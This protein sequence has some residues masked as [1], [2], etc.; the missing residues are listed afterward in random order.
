MFICTNAIGFA[1]HD[2]Y[3]PHN[4]SLSLEPLTAP[5]LLRHDDF[6]RGTLVVCA[7]SVAGEMLASF[8]QNAL[9][10]TMGVYERVQK[11]AL[12]RVSPNTNTSLI[13]IRSE[14]RRALL[15]G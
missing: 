2:D 7:S 4:G 13:R 6:P 12:E 9:L 8:A 14:C 5:I 15:S 10:A 3:F 11:G 1:R